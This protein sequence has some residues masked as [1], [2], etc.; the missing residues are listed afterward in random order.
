MKEPTNQKILSVSVLFDSSC[1]YDKRV[2]EVLAAGVDYQ[3]NN[4]LAR[5]IAYGKETSYGT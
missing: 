3:Y 2:L 1:G 4:A 5:D